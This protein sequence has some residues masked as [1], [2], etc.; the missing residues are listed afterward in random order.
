MTLVE[1]A[2]SPEASPHDER[3]ADAG[4]A[5]GDAGPSGSVTH[6]SLKTKQKDAGD[7]GDAHLRTFS[8]KPLTENRTCVE[9]CGALNGPEQLYSIDDKSLWLH[10][11]FQRF[12]CERV[13]R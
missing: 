9:C 10:P 12:F 4:D 2:E 1:Q 5:C 3:E 6:K 13:Y 11:E 8:G 7:A